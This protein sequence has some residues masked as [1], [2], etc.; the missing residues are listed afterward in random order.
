MHASYTG[1][2]FAFS[3]ATSFEQSLVWHSLFAIGLWSLVGLVAIFE[4]RKAGVQ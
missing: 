3:P 4:R 2:Q 1:W